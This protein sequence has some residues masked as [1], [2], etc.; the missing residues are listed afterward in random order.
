MPNPAPVAFDRPGGGPSQ[1][2]RRRPV[3]LAY[4]ARQT[5]G[6]R[7]VE[8]EVLAIFAHQAVAVRDRFASADRGERLYLAHSLKGS[9]RNIGA[10]ALAKCAEEIEA[11]PDDRK[12]LQSIVA[13][14][15]EVSDF[16]AAISR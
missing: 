11:H 4:L 15:D 12:A 13:A 2:S 7:A 1:A 16:I 10:F 5:M 3:D 6:D 14:I 9:A 8:E